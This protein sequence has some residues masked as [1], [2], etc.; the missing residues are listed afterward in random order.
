MRARVR[1]TGSAPPRGAGEDRRPPPRDPLLLP[2]DAGRRLVSDAGGTAGVN[3]ALGSAPP[4]GA[5]EDRRPP[6]R[7][8]LLLPDDA[9]RRL[10]SDAGGT[11]GVNPALGSTPPIN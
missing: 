8:P 7:D 4:R 3:P 5:G 1:T 11:A 6:P 10:V 2:D 9:G